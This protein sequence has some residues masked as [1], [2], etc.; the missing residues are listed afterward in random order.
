MSPSDSSRNSHFGRIETLTGEPDAAQARELLEDAARKAL[1]LMQRRGWRVGI[2]REF[3]PQSGQLLGLN[4]NRGREVRIRLRRLRGTAK[5]PRSAAPPRQETR[6]RVRTL[7]DVPGAPGSPFFSRQEV[8][9]TLLHELVHIEIGPHNDAFYRLLD[10]LFSE[11]QQRSLPA[12]IPPGA[13]AARRAMPSGGG[14]HLSSRQPRRVGKRPH[15]SLLAD[16]AERRLQAAR[17]SISHS[18][19][20]RLGTSVVVAAPPFGWRPDMSPAEAASWAAMRRWED[21]QRCGV[22][23]VDDHP[24]A[25]STVIDVD[26]L[27][28]DDPAP[29]ITPASGHLSRPPHLT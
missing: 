9:G 16:A 21:A 23:E 29:S 13:S 3:L 22:I 26:V 18:G 14:R 1:P 12:P 10:E 24:V 25:D 5:R 17:A 2:L 19:G 27:F 8:L 20:V 15:A 6:R 7:A 4:V 11:V 28:P